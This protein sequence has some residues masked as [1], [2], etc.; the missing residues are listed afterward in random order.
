MEI[1]RRRGGAG[2]DPQSIMMSSEQVCCDACRSLMIIK[3]CAQLEKLDLLLGLL[4]LLLLLLVL[5]CV[6]VVGCCCCCCG[7]SLR[8]LL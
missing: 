2:L 8:L 7:C 4:C 1:G 3:R 6:Y 5:C